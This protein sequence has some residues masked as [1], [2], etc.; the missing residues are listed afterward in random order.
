M[1]HTAT[2]ATLG[3]GATTDEREIKRAYARLLKATRPEDDPQGFQDLRTAYEAALY[4]AR[5]GH[6]YEYDEQEEYAEQGE[7]LQAAAADAGVTVPPA[8]Y[9]PSMRVVPVLRDEAADT[10][11]AVERAPGV[12][13]PVDEAR[14]FFIGLIPALSAHPVD[15]LS[16]ASRSDELLN[17]DVREC[18]EVCAAEYGASEA[19]PDNVRDAM[20]EHFGW[21]EDASHLHERAPWAAATVLARWRAAASWAHF[22]QFRASDVVV[23]HV[24]SDKLPGF[25][26]R[27]LDAGFMQRMRSLLE[28]I[29]WQHADM[30]EYRLN[31]DVFAEWEARVAAKRYYVQTAVYSFIAGVLA[32]VGLVALFGAT[33][34]WFDGDRG[35][36]SM[37]GTQ[38]LTF[39]AIALLKFNPPQA[40]YD[41]LRTLRDDALAPRVDALRY[42]PRLRYGWIAVF[43]ALSFAMFMPQ[44]LPFA[45][46]VALGAV[47]WAC[48]LVAGFM[49]WDAVRGWRAML[50][51]T[52]SGIGIGALMELHGAFPGFPFWTGLPFG[53]TLCVLALK[54]G[55]ELVDWLGI[56]ARTL[57]QVRYA[58]LAG[59]AIIVVFVGMD[60]GASTWLHLAAWVLCL[61]GLLLSRATLS[62]TLAWPALVLARVFAK[63]GLGDMARDNP[64]LPLLL[65]ALLV[66]G[67]FMIIN[68]YRAD[69]AQNSFS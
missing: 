45:D 52:L 58:W 49:H 20:V 32:W 26:L 57:Q 39:G 33:T 61:T 44:P 51:I 19:C 37:L 34:T 53:A 69:E 50:V 60:A 18:F 14:R 25:V 42:D 5:E 47:M 27:T 46:Q 41:K 54:G 35:L 4:Y 64:R 28:T 8:A 43:A 15:T 68:M 2:W 30:L 62:W 7:E 24:L 21:N 31:Q 1:S 12:A 29:R 56:N 63:E 16:K 66:V 17:F 40:L 9:A 22:S 59:A 6:K 3:I 36:L 23:R 65:G 13:D 67:I 48:L 55:G 38:A 11:Q 10:A